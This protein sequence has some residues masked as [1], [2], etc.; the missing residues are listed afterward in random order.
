MLCTVPGCQSRKVTQSRCKR[1]GG[2]RRC[3]HPGCLRSAQGAVAP[4]RCKVHGG[5][6]RCAVTGCTNSSVDAIHAPDGSRRDDSTLRCKKHGGGRRCNFEGCP[7][8]AQAGGGLPACIEHGGGRRCT[9]AGCTRSARGTGDK[10]LCIRHSRAPKVPRAPKA[11][12]AQG[13]R[14]RAPPCAAPPGRFAARSGWQGL[15]PPHS[16]LP[17]P[18]VLLPPSL[19]LLPP[20]PRKRPR[21][22]VR[23]QSSPLHSKEA[24]DLLLLLHRQPPETAP[25]VSSGGNSLARSGEW[26]EACVVASV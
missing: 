6:H 5:G 21:V 14:K 10:Q 26:A 24:I 20:S 12:R 13:S 8:S 25:H 17:P 15:P 22:A 23:Q 19:A 18:L 16:L 11:P 7:K 9:T 3:E 2:G 1:H 4:P